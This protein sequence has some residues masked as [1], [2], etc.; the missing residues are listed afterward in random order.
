VSSTQKISATARMIVPARSRKA[1]ALLQ[2]C[3][4]P[5]LRGEQLDR[6]HAVGGQFHVEARGSPPQHRAIEERRGSQRREAAQHVKPQHDQGLEAQNP[7]HAH[8]RNKGGDEQ[9]VDRKARGAGH[10]GRHQDGREAIPGRRDG[11]RREYA[12]NGAG[13]AREERDEAP[14]LQAR[15]PHDAI[16]H[17]CR[18]RQIAHVF[19]EVNQGEQDHDLREENQHCSETRE[20]AVDPEIGQEARGQHPRGKTP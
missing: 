18:A 17:E 14:P 4:A 15:P 12:G 5:D 16:D 7:A 6:R 9:R 10:E 11:A 19:E 13:E 20:H 1:L 2:T 3:A 8:R